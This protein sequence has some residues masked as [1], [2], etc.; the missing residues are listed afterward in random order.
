MP[1]F[2]ILFPVYNEENRLEEGIEKTLKFIETKMPEEDFQLTIV[3]NASS[4]RTE[5][6]ARKLEQ[7][8]AKV[9]Y[10]RIEEKGVGAAFRA[11][12]AANTA[13]IVGYMD[14][15]LSTDLRTLLI[16]RKIFKKLPS[17]QMVNASKQAKRAITI[18]RSPL[19]NLTSKCLTLLMK[20]ALKMKASDAICGFK[21][22]RREFAEVLIQKADQTENGWFFIIELL[23]LAERSR[24]R[25]EEVP[26][27][28]TEAEGGHVN[29]IHQSADYIKNILKLR[30]R[31][32]HGI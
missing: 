1:S 31:L 4:D 12:V 22:F 14:V 28:Y 18:G 23:I 2:N 16:M 5:E 25:V 21:F 11:G 7:L 10:I 13:D 6:I 9:S 27:I 19:R 8:H 26:V 15:D 20:A 32:K 30:R 17:V 3:D 24:A 29:V